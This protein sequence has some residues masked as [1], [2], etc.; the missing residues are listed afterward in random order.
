MKL[1]GQLMR[2]AVN[3]VTTPV[4]IVQDVVEVSKSMIGE[5]LPSKSHTMEHLEQLK[6]EAGED[7]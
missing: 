3:V 2:T 7:E 1:F 4:A 5:P 6:R